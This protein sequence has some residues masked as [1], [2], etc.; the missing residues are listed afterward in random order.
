VQGVN[1]RKAPSLRFGPQELSLLGPRDVCY[2]ESPWK[3][4]PGLTSH[5]CGARIA[6]AGK[7]G[8]AKAHQAKR[9]GEKK[10]GGSKQKASE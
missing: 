9:K 8:K 6:R 3:I 1:Q 2:C 10:S 7:T 5:R 4:F